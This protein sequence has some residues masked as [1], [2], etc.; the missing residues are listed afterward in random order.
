MR[1]DS[2]LLSSF[3]EISFA[4][5]EGRAFRHG[6]IVRIEPNIG[7]ARSSHCRKM[8]SPNSLNADLVEDL[9]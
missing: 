2:M 1:A 9:L 3:Y 7:N 8:F 6:D 4:Y 5:V